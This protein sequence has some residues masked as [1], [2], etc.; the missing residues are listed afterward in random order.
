VLLL[1]QWLVAAHACTVS[2]VRPAGVAEAVVSHCDA[3]AAPDPAG[4]SSLCAEHCHQGQ[5]SDQVPVLAL[6]AAVLAEAYPLPAPR[7]M[8]VRTV[9]RAHAPDALAA[10]PPPHAVLHCCFRL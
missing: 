3:M 4:P 10:P 6:P 5:Q 8:A 1:A 7:D 9:P 2:W